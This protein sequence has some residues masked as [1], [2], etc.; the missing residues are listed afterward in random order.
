MS[1]KLHNTNDLFP[2]RQA[3]SEARA[4]ARVSIAVP[5]IDVM[6]RSAVGACIPFTVLPAHYVGK[7]VRIVIA[8]GADD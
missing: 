6:F 4:V 3:E 2:A 1:R 5:T 7:K 8:D